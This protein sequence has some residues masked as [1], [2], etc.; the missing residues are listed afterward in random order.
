MK[1][2]ERRAEY[3]S[4]LGNKNGYNPKQDYLVYPLFKVEYPRQEHFE[5]IDLINSKIR[6]YELENLSYEDRAVKFLIDTK[7]VLKLELVKHDYYFQSDK[8]K[9]DIY[10]VTLSRGSRSYTF[11]FGQSITNSAL[12]YNDDLMFT[13]YTL[14]KRTYKT[15]IE[16]EIPSAY[17]ILASLFLDHELLEVDESTAFDNFISNY[18]YN[19]NSK[20][21]LRIFRAC[22][23][24][25]NQLRLLYNDAELEMLNAIN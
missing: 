2:Q 15:Q 18:G 7:S 25:S 20:G 22:L 14:N 19:S 10:K 24:Q 3:I 11:T 6:R 17:D 1:S 13:C 8:E 21:T 4:K 9:R 23:E 12:Q 16:R 5:N